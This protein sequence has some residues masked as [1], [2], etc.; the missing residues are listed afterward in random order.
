VVRAEGGAEALGFV[1][2]TDRH[3]GNGFVIATRGGGGY[4]KAGRQ[5]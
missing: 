4:G 3:P 1:A 2:S 5:I